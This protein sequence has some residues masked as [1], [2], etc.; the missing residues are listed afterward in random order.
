VTAGV[1]SKARIAEAALAPLQ[2]ARATLRALTG[3]P[4]WMGRLTSTL[5]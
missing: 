3:M 4:T 5:G 1:T 2:F